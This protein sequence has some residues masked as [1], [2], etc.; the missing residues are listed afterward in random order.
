MNGFKKLGKTSRDTNENTRVEK[1]ISRDRIIHG[2][3]LTG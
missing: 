3:E 2:T 1:K